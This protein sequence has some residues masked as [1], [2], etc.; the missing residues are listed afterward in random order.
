MSAVS[1]KLALADLDQLIHYLHKT[2]DAA[3]V[4]VFLDGDLAAGKTTLVQHYAGCEGVTS[5]TFS[6]QNCY[7]DIYHY[8]LYTIDSE[9]FFASGLVYELEKKGQHF[10]EWGDERLKQFCLDAGFEVVNIKI[11]NLGDTREYIIY[12]T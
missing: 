7:G 11:E 3:D 9:K 2:L 5:P 4:I 10:I 12:G 8:D 6:L 1:F